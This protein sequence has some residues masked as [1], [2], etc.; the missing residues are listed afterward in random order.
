M[1]SVITS[2]HR[3]LAMQQYEQRHQHA[4]K[5]CCVYHLKSCEHWD[6]IFVFLR[7]K[8]FFTLFLGMGTKCLY[9]PYIWSAENDGGLRL[10][11]LP[12]S[13][14]AARKLRLGPNIFS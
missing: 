6:G 11:F 13:L 7:T 12:F 8:P 9:R 3:M 14:L 4:D 5:H 10:Q 1:E 2:P